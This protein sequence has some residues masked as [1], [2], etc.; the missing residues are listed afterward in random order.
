MRRRERTAAFRHADGLAILAAVVLVA[1]T[2]AALAARFWWGFELFSH[3][4]LQYFAAQFPLALVLA[5]LGRRRFAAVVALAAVPNVLPLAPYLSPG[6]Q[7]AANG[8]TLEVVAVNVEWRNPHAKA[9]LATLE[10]ESPDVIVVVELTDTWVERLRPVVERY[11]HRLLAPERGAFGI[12][13]L[14]RYPLEDAR[15][16]PLETTTAID[17][18]IAAPG[19]PLRLIGVHLRPPMTAADA[20]ERHR[21]LDHLAALVAE[22]NE[23]TAICGDFNLTPY[24][25]EFTDFARRTGMRDAR[26]GRGPGITW[27][28]SLP[29]LGIPIDHCLVSPE[30]GV[31]GFRRLAAFGSDHYPIA[32]GLFIEDDA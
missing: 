1:V 7:A 19:G 21:Q 17:A 11:P 26:A 14:S 13:L 29:I 23:P 32:A 2:L 16:F 28:T 12:G 18:R 5:M 31:A 25:P 6:A 3:F 22:R 30:I 4:R 9:L 15:A 10:A 20:A 24:S 27:P 8:R